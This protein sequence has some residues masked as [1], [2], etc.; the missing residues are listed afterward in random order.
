MYGGFAVSPRLSF[1]YL[2]LGFL[3]N[4][5]H[6]YPTKDELNRLVR[7]TGLTETQV[8]NWFNNARRRHKNLFNLPERAVRILHGWFS[9]HV[10][11][12]QPSAD[13]IHALC[14]QIGLGV[15]A[16]TVERW[17]SHARTLHKHLTRQSDGTSVD[18]GSDS[19]GPETFSARSSP[20]DTATG[21]PRTPHGLRPSPSMGQMTPTR[22]VGSHPIQA[23]QQGG[24]PVA[25]SLMRNALPL[26]P[27]SATAAA[28]AG[29]ASMS[30]MMPT[31]PLSVT[32]SPLRNQGLAAQM[33]PMPPQL[34]SPQGSAPVTPT[35]SGQ[36]SASMRFPMTQQQFPVGGLVCDCLVLLLCFS[37]TSI[38]ADVAT[39]ADADA[40]ANDGRPEQLCE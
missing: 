4:I 23:L 31:M 34:V 32:H 5:L 7:E 26:M 28:G 17:I 39:A 30:M 12:P 10:N 3:N 27:G 33:P 8:T 35:G 15:T 1:S 2:L 40:G 11:D 14:Q 16:A 38:A 21:T 25:P 22:P 9:E 13:E 24:Q 36:L 37:H 29:P 19:H 20:P 6:P 18:S